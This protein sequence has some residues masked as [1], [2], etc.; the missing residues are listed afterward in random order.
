MPYAMLQNFMQFLPIYSYPEWVES[1]DKMLKGSEHS[2]PTQSKVFYFIK[3]QNLPTWVIIVIFSNGKFP[4]YH[5]GLNGRI[6]A[7]FQLTSLSPVWGEDHCALGLS[8]PVCVGELSSCPSTPP[9]T[10]TPPSSSPLSPLLPSAPPPPL[11]PGGGLA[12]LVIPRWMWVSE[13]GALPSSLS[14]RDR[15][16]GRDPGYPACT[17]S[18]RTPTHTHT[19]AH[20]HTV[21]YEHKGCRRMRT[22]SDTHGWADKNPHRGKQVQKHCIVLFS[23]CF[24]KGII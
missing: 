19:H 10:H 22:H 8:D 11:R 3:I 16:P 2:Q 20:F 15:Q 6:S 14:K 12:V 4:I 23:V 24:R 18:P 13:R 1:H 9:H 7:P 5:P 21:T 17:R